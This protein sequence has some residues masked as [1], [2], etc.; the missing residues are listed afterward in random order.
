MHAIVFHRAQYHT[1][2]SKISVRVQTR[3]FYTHFNFFYAKVLQNI[4][5]KGA[6]AFDV[7]SPL[8]AFS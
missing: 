7:Y 5:A 6:V 2:T 8:C 3:A 1:L 4:Q